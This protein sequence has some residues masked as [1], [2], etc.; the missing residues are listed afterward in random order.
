MVASSTAGKRM[1]THGPPL[2]EQKGQQDRHE[3]AADI[4]AREVE[5]NDRE[6]DTDRYPVDRCENVFAGA[7][8]LLLS[9]P[10]PG[11]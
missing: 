8:C 9:L 10:V 1:M 7:P 4:E 2:A 6:Y 11:Q 5:T 3:D